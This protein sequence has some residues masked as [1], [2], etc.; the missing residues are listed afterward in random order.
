MRFSVYESSELN[1]PQLNGLTGSLVALL[2]AVLVNGYGTRQPLGWLKPLP[3]D[4]LTGSLGCWQQPSGSGMILYI[5]DNAPTG[6]IIGAGR[7]A[8]ATGYET[9]LGL[10]S[11][12]YPTT[13]TGSG[14]FPQASQTF[15][16]VAAGGVLSG[17][18]W[19]RKSTSADDVRRYWI[20]FGD[21][22]TF[23]LF[24]QTGDTTGTFYG[25][26][27]GDFY[28]FRHDPYRCTLH[29]RC[30]N[31]TNALTYR[32]DGSDSGTFPTA[33]TMYMDW[34]SRSWTGVPGGYVVNKIIDSGKASFAFEASTA[35][36]GNSAPI[37]PFAGGVPL[38]DQLF[39][40]QVALSETNGVLRGKYR[41]MYHL[42]HPLDGLNNGMII[43]GSNE[44]MGKYFRLV[45]P[46]PY[47]G[48][49]LME[50]SDTLDTN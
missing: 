38:T 6:S 49:W 41:G 31:Q 29:G 22:Y 32:M 11:S 2:D 30:A 21:A 40:Q 13:G 50:I 15:G 43:T 39:I 1:A 48:G 17:S 25:Y 14:Q 23:Y 19:W 45:K 3:N 12:I 26:W 47:R 10:T 34:V 36:G 44:Q 18:V 4:S 33:T 37:A 16:T 5:N 42:C 8:W 28:S 7:E 27:F 24:V 20:L 9:I 35:P 46:G